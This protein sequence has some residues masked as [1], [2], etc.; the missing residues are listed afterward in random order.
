VTFIVH[1]ES[2]GF[3]NSVSDIGTIAAIEIAGDLKGLDVQCTNYFQRMD[4]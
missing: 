3:T 2:P 4:R 1:D